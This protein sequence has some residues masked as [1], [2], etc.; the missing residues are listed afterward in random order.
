MERQPDNSTVLSKQ[1]MWC[2]HV[3]IETLVSV[4]PSK[5]MCVP[6]VEGWLSGQWI[7]E[8]NIIY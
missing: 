7:I 1:L 5:G 6:N 4:S 2:K 8:G 3:S